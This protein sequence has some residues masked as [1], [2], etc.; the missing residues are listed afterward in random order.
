MRVPECPHG[1]R[2][3]LSELCLQPVPLIDGVLVEKLKPCQWILIQAEGEVYALCVVVA[4][5]ILNG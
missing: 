1:A 3:V 4:T 5:S 2:K